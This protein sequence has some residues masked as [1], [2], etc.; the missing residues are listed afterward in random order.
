MDSK[1][2]A[3]SIQVQIL[4]GVRLIYD[5]DLEKKIGLCLID[6]RMVNFRK[7]RYLIIFFYSLGAGAKIQARN[8]LNFLFEH[9]VPLGN[10]F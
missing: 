2:I 3:N 4:S 1:S 7:S 9:R 8:F 5:F 10:S 6:H